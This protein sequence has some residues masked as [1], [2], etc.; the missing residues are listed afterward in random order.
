MMESLDALGSLENVSSGDDQS[1]ID[2][3]SSLNT[4][5]EP[6][7]IS[8]LTSSNETTPVERYRYRILDLHRRIRSDLR[9]QSLQHS[10]LLLTKLRELQFEFDSTHQTMANLAHHVNN[11]TS[12]LQSVDVRTQHLRESTADLTKTREHVSRRSNLVSAFVAN[13]TLTKDETNILMNIDHSANAYCHPLIFSI[14]NKLH[15][16][17]QHAQTVLKRKHTI[18]DVQQNSADTVAT[19][20]NMTAKQKKKENKNHGGMKSDTFDADMSIFETILSEEGSSLALELYENATR[21]EERAL[22]DL[23]DFLVFQITYL[24]VDL[25][26]ATL[27]QWTQLCNRQ[28][29][30]GNISGKNSSPPVAIPVRPKTLAMGLYCLRQRPVL[31]NACLERLIKAQRD[32]LSL[33]LAKHLTGIRSALRTA[34][35]PLR[36]AQ[37]RYAWWHQSFAT[38]SELVHAFF[39]YSLYQSDNS[40]ESKR[41]LIPSDLPSDLPSDFSDNKGS[42]AAI[43]FIIPRK[44]S[45]KKIENPEVRKKRE[46]DSFVNAILERILRIAG[47]VLQDHMFSAMGITSSISSDDVVHFN[48]L[49]NNVNV[50]QH[51]INNNHSSDNHGKKSAAF[52][53]RERRYNEQQEKNRKSHDNTGSSILDQED[54]DLAIPELARL[55]VQSYSFLSLTLFY[56]DTITRLLSSKDIPE[57]TQKIEERVSKE[58]CKESSSKMNDSVDLDSKTTTLDLEA[59]DLEIYPSVSDILH[60]CEIAAE[61]YFLSLLGKLAGLIMNI[62]D[63]LKGIVEIR[64]GEKRTAL[65]ESTTPKSSY[66]GSAAA[67]GSTTGTSSN[68]TTT[69]PS[70]DLAIEQAMDNNRNNH[71]RAASDHDIWRTSHQYNTNDSYHYANQ[72]TLATTRLTTNIGIMLRELSSASMLALG[73][74]KLPPWEETVQACLNPVLRLLNFQARCMESLDRS[75][76]FIINNLSYLR[77]LQDE[78]RRKQNKTNRNRRRSSRSAQSSTSEAST[79]GRGSEKSSTE[80]ETFII[81]ATWVTK[82]Q[83]MESEKK[84]GW[85]QRRS[86]SLL[87]DSL[88]MLKVQLSSPQND[89]ETSH[90]EEYVNRFYGAL[91]TGQFRLEVTTSHDNRFENESSGDGFRCIESFELKEAMKDEVVKVIVKSYREIYARYCEV[92]RGVDVNADI[93]RM[94]EIFVHHPDE[95]QTLIL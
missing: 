62:G 64:E 68:S 2:S 61:H 5:T 34:H 90:I 38:Q 55:I 7:A 33:Q 65:L 52:L 48:E 23:Y 42:D 22:N 37:D 19:T 69:I 45:R 87:R 79:S 95:I 57:R 24:F 89:M 86:Q 30:P 43:D 85:I 27:E 47:P 15:L 9:L 46:H 82:L 56:A 94:R 6:S 44:D 28:N 81:G 54:S 58:E 84:K 17:R 71:H 75:D 80:E 59:L 41:E 29:I 8:L 73:N 77:N 31:Y 26:L 67:Y 4:E 32:C 21:L 76:I 72:Q 63:E 20:H 66:N 13:F 83:D 1:A 3:N 91:L 70:F 49:N 53:R 51:G 18:L 78:R 36:Y 50:N 10:S 35:D 92:D 11:I 93:V 60:D 88:G 12:T 39:P 14:L 16:T 25:R 40:D 74:S